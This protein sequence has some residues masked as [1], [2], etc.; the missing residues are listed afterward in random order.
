MIA[1]YGAAT[2]LPMEEDAPQNPED[3]YGIA[4][5]AVEQDLR[6]AHAMFG[7]DYVIFRPH[8]VYG[9]RQNIADKFRNAV[10]IFMNQLLRGESITIFGDGKQTRGF[11]YISDV[12]PVIAIAPFISGARNNDFFVGRDEQTSLNDLSA[13]VARAMGKPLRREYLPR[14]HE[15]THAYA[16]HVKLRC[17]FNPPEP[18]GLADGLNRTAAYALRLGSFEPTGY[19]AIEVRRNLPP[20]WDAALRSWRKRVYRIGSNYRPAIIKNGSG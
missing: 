10:G 14:R 16:S 7:L 17:V 19:S 11:S 8:N 15:V 13:M 1:A 4:K 9:P 20:S 2:K 12:A 5:H 6:A 18:V 3:P